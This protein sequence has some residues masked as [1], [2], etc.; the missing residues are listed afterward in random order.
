MNPNYIMIDDK[1][2]RF[3]DKKFNYAIVGASNNTVKYGYKIVKTLHDAGFTAIPVNPKEY[4]V[5]DLQCY[6]SLADVK[7]RIDVVDFVVPAK[8]T[9]KIL[10]TIKGSQ[11]RRVWFQP[12][13][14]NEDCINFCVKNKISYMKDFCLYAQALNNI[15]NS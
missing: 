9:L 7:E 3:F 2:K 12:G 1:L 15:E 8:V 5:Y 13:S 10:E 6:P 14:Y 11:I 4:K